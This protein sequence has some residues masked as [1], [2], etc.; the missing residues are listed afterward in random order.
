MDSSEYNSSVKNSEK[1]I[2]QGVIDCFF[3]E[4]DGQAVLV[5]Y[6]TDKIKNG[7][8]SE[9]VENYTLQ[10]E[11]YSKAIEQVAEVR[12]KERYLYLFDI[13]KAVKI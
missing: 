13:N 7:D 12:V 9:V 11:L 8:T 3:I 10:L 4:D 5:D 6:K 2:L 1:M